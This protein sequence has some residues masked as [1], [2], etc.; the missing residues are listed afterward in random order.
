MNLDLEADDVAAEVKRLETL[1]A[2]RWDHQKERGY[3]FWVMRDPWDNEFCV[4]Q[5]GVPRAASSKKA[6][7]SLLVLTRRDYGPRAGSM[8][9]NDPPKKQ[10]CPT[11][12][13][14][15]GWWETGV[16]AGSGKRDGATL[17]DNRSKQLGITGDTQL[18]VGSGISA[19]HFPE[20]FA[21][22]LLQET[23]S[24]PA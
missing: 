5:T 12:N 7:E 6:V 16:R 17:D 23:V 22:L 15:G 19:D 21:E 13:G 14:E 20:V 8:A 1:G 11:R 10:S 3:D 9:K 4:L 24:P 2:S 18:P